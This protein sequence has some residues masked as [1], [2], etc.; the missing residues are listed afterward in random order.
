MF[1]LSFTEIVVIL[2]VA[3]IFIKP[4]DIPRLF[5]KLGKLYGRISRQVTA[6]RKIVTELE[7][8][9]RLAEE[10]ESKLEIEDKEKKEKEIK[11]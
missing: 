2:I 5:T 4:K 3:L 9:V 7:D 11:E 10:I 6:A 8:E 1:G